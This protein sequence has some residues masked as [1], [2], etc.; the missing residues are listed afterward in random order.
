M[1]TYIFLSM[2][3]P[4]ILATE[5]YFIYTVAEESI[6]VRYIVIY[7]VIVNCIPFLI[8]HALFLT[9]IIWK[10]LF[11]GIDVFLALMASHILASVAFFLAERQ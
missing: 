8:G 3:L 10:R 2:V 1:T 11:K 5:L 7:E 9:L 4:L 6:D